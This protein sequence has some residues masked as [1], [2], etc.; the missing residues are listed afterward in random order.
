MLVNNNNY[1]AQ[2]LL[3]TIFLFPDAVLSGD[4]A[5]IQTTMED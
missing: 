4:M 5:D 1:P 2:T 3:K